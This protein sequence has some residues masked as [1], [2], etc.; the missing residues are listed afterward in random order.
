MFVHGTN[1]PFGSV[2][3]IREALA[4]IPA[5]TEL[6]TIQNGGHDLRKG[7]FNI[8]QLVIGPFQTMMTGYGCP[9][10]AAGNCP[11]TDSS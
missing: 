5:K 1:D 11:V 8:V 7:S 9:G 6:V 3:E 4:L 2:E 10:T